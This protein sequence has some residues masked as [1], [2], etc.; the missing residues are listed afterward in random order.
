MV[1]VA[2]LPRGDVQ[3][4]F[5]LERLD[6]AVDFS[7]ADQ[8]FR[9]EEVQLLQCVGGAERRRTFYRLWTLKEAMI[10]ATGEGL[11]RKLDTFWFDLFPPRVHL[12]PSD[13]TEAWW[14]FE[15]R[16]I[17][18]A[19]VA[20]AAVQ[21]ADGVERRTRWKLLALRELGQMTRTGVS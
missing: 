21:C 7:V 17:G 18:R 11:S 10:K 2:V 19:F 1:G 9:P 3:V 8:F 13:E 20:A 6:R 12:A 16:L 14:H 5:D 15:Q 4:G